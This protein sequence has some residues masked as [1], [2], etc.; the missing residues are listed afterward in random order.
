MCADVT[1]LALF[2]WHEAMRSVCV[3]TVCICVYSG[4]WRR[5]RL[6]TNTGVCVCVCT[7]LH[8]YRWYCVHLYILHSCWSVGLCIHGCVTQGWGGVYGARVRVQSS[9]CSTGM[10]TNWC[11]RCAQCVYCSICEHLF[12]CAIWGEH[13]LMNVSTGDPLL[14]HADMAV[15]VNTPYNIT[16]V[17]YIPAARVNSNYFRG[18]IPDIHL[19]FLCLLKKIIVNIINLSCSCSFKVIIL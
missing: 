18:C 14:V 17:Q 9:L 1:M 15:L 10:M 4:V 19:V 13:S 12:A 5:E 6:G 7:I 8:K 11:I 2:V 16:P 3:S